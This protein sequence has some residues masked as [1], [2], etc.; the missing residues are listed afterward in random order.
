MAFAFFFFFFWCCWSWNVPFLSTYVLWV[1]YT[2][3]LSR[4][5]NF[6]LIDL[7]I[8]ASCFEVAIVWLGLYGCCVVLFWCFFFFFISEFTNQRFLCLIVRSDEGDSPSWVCPNTSV[9]RFCSAIKI[10]VM[11][12]IQMVSSTFSL[13]ANTL[14]KW[15][16]NRHQTPWTLPPI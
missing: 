3:C 16:A 11:Q 8:A 2:R 4:I 6:F 12:V 7:C 9:A 13:G 14:C 1:N 15:P 5:M 10:S